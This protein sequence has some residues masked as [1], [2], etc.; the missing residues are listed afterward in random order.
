M[1]A[2]ETELSKAPLLEHLIELR[3][4]LLWSLAAILV[5]FIGCYLV[6]QDIYNFLVQP[7]AE[8]LKGHPE[9][10]MIYTQLYEGF[11]TQV[12]VSLYAALMLAFPIIA[13]QIWMF[14]APGLY[15]HEKKAFLPFLI[16]TPVL[17]LCGAAMAYYIVFPAAWHF[18]LSFEM[19]AD[20]SNLKIVLQ[21]KVSEYLSL[22]MTMIFAFG[23]CF[24]LPVLLV[25]LGRIGIVT[26]EMLAGARRYAL[27]GIFIV[28]AVVT[29]PDAFSQIA[30]GVPI[31][32]LYE[33]S[34][35]CIRMVEK[36]RA[37]QN[38]QDTEE[39]AED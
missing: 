24:E 14:V 35:I 33:I 30:L 12:K 15:R 37:E 17:F 9:H 38:G 11:L 6:S 7:L 32:L 22:V 18:F 13:S 5:A 27:V 4:R 23:F 25:L 36:K 39:M 34:I 29:P 2:D 1:E 3:R 19:P 28:A 8:A 26:S 31:Y 16:A 20:Q 21:P 10:Q